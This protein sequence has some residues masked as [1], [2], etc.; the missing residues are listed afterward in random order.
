MTRDPTMPDG[1]PPDPPLDE[2]Q[3]AT[4]RAADGLETA[5]DLLLLE[6]AG[7]AAPEIRAAHMRL[8]KLM[9]VSHPAPELAPHVLQ[10]LGLSVVDVRP[11]LLHG[12][13][14]PPELAGTVLDSIGQSVVRGREALL[15][16][17]G[18]APDVAPSVMQTLQL[19]AVQGGP[20]LLD[21]AGAAP[22]LSESVLDAL[23]LSRTTARESLLDGV[24]AP[25][26]LAGRVLDAVDVSGLRLRDVL[27]DSAGQAPNMAGDILDR[28]SLPTTAGTVD[29]VLRAEAGPPPDLS[30]AVLSQLGITEAASV[31]APR[32]TNVVP[33][34]R[35]WALLA[36]PVVAMAAAALLFVSQVLISVAPTD[37]LIAFSTDVANRIEIED[38]STDASAVVHIIPGDFDDFA[39]PTI[40][41]IDELDEEPDTGD[42][43]VKGKKR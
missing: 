29:E 22:E 17:A 16:D 23:A 30:G 9:A 40:I 1:A 20:A 32:P 28:L 6:N 10:S 38:I 41:F 15:V 31:S 5:E 35:R 18:V 36:V 13:G 14:V 7:L 21:G 37:E 19:D 33:L 27:L 12:A 11:V 42:G 26:E 34:R 4:L 43:R 3:C 24:D 8:S 25:P 2:L 39:A